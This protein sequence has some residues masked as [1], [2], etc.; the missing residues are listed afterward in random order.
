[1]NSMLSV[2]PARIEDAPAIAAVH[3][4]SWQETY[5]GLM[6][7]KILDDPRFVSRHERFWNAV[8]SDDQRPENRVAVAEHDGQIVGIA[9]SGAPLEDDWPWGI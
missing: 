9:F 1:M 4:R 8:L 5:R 3:V 7:A 6:S 2:R